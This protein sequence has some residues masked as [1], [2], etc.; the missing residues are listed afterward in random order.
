[1]RRIL[2]NKNFQGVF[3]V[4][5]DLKKILL[6]LK[7]DFVDES[8]WLYNDYKI[9]DVVIF[10]IRTIHAS[11]RFDLKITIFKDYKK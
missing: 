4:T 9:G 5:E 10:D 11:F 2:I 6:I 8:T 3:L 1:M 7:I